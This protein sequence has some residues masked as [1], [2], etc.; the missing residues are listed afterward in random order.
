MTIGQLNKN[1]G[2]LENPPW[3]AE[4]DEWKE[5]FLSVPFSTILHTAGALR[6]RDSVVG[7][8]GKIEVPALVVVGESDDPTPPVCS[9]EIASALPKAALVVVKNAG[10]LSNLEQP[11]AVTSAMVSYLKENMG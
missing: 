7:Q 6:Y 4:E 10:H 2:S 3:Q 9:R 11:A 8:L 5:R 1:V